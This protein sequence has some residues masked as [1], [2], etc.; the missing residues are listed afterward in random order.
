MMSDY[1]TMNE[2]ILTCK[3]RKEVNLQSWLANGAM[4]ILRSLIL[5]PNSEIRLFIAFSHCLPQ[6]ILS[7]HPVAFIRLSLRMTM[8]QHR[9]LH[10]E[11]VR[12]YFQQMNPVHLIELHI[13]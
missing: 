11:P 7:N 8:H 1:E 10:E 4:E 13:Y 3:K 6:E 12:E 2:A 5:L 9:C